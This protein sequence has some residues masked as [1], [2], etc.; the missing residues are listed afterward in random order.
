[1]HASS[2]EIRQARPEELDRC[3]EIRR[4]V[5]VVDQGVPEALERD[6]RD[7]ECEHF[8]A[9]SAGAAVGAARLRELEGCAKL[10]RVAV[11]AEHRGAGLGRALVRAAEARATERGLTEIVLSAQSAVVD[12]YLELGYRTEGEPFLE[13]GIPHV[14][15]RRALG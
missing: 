15:M 11:L 12:F 14:H 10:E 3:L 1:M 9:L 13:A 5:F 7:P 6:G 4:A 8:I 2:P